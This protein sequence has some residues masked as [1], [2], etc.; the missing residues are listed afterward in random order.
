MK[1]VTAVGPIAL[2]ASLVASPPVLAANQPGDYSFTAAIGESGTKHDNSY[3]SDETIQFSLLYQKSGFAAYRATAGLLSMS[4]REIISPA[5]GTRDADAF[6]VTGDLL[7]TPR[8]RVL[9][10]FLAAGVGFYDVRLSDDRDNTNDIELGVNWGL[11]MD[12]QLLR[13][14]AIHGEVAYHYLTGAVSN[15]IQTIVVGGRFDF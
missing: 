4:G 11:G 8:F 2:L 13:W 12:V 10:P 14:F 9:H 3:R 7:F 6:F 15:P 1:Q 5:A